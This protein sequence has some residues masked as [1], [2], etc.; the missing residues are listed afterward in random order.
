[1][2]GADKIHLKQIKAPCN[3]TG[4]DLFDRTRKVRVK[5][6]LCVCVYQATVMFLKCNTARVRRGRSASEQI[7]KL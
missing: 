3:R 1:M 2:V 5:F 7:Q 4:T 6:K